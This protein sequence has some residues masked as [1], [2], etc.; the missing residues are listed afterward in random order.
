MA[1]NKKTLNL[2]VFSLLL[3]SCVIVGKGGFY[4]PENREYLKKQTSQGII[5][6]DATFPFFEDLVIEI[7]LQGRIGGGKEF[8]TIIPPLMWIKTNKK[9]EENNIPFQVELFIKNKSS[10]Y[11]KDKLKVYLKMNNRVYKPAAKYYTCN[12]DTKEQC[13][14][15]EFPLKIKDVKKGVLIIEYEGTQKELPFEYDLLW[16][17]N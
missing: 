13:R 15:F 6:Y 1:A 9:F 14:F 7:D 11:S 12:F 5:S 16:Y 17:T 3:S 2:L 10:K 4:V 8:E